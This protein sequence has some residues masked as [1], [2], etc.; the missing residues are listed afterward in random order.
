[1]AGVGSLSDVS[2]QCVW[3]QQQQQMVWHTSA[4]AFNPPST[5]D[6]QAPIDRQAQMAMASLPHHF[7]QRY[8]P[9]PLPTPPHVPLLRR[10][11]DQPPLSLTPH[12]AAVM[13]CGR[14]LSP[15]TRDCSRSSL[16]DPPVLV[17]ALVHFLASM[18]TACGVSW[19]AYGRVR[20]DL[21]D[22]LALHDGAAARHRPAAS[23]PQ[24]SAPPPGSPPPQHSPPHPRGE[25]TIHMRPPCFTVLRRLLTSPMALWCGDALPRSASPTSW[26][27]LH[28]QPN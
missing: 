24:L 1:M 18:L 7:S 19:Q 5:L 22:L 15:A 9:P 2:K 28:E 21:L 20:G 23:P 6:R 26:L 27:C 17:N 16:D 13:L 3:R 10:A 12:P 4:S 14:F 25:S 8:T 11:R